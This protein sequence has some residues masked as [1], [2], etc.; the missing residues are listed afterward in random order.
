MK[1]G[2]ALGG[3]GAKGLAHIPLLQVFDDLGIRPHRI[4]GTSIGA[5]IGAL[6]ASGRSA[7]EI[8]D[9]IDELLFAEESHEGELRFA[10]LKGLQ[11][12]GQLIDFDTSAGGI[13]KGDD[14]V[15]ALQSQLGAH[16]F[17][18][19]EIP[20]S[21]VATD[22]WSREPFVFES[23]S[24]AQAV[25]ASAS[26]PGLFAPVIEDGR[27]LMD[28][29]AVNPVPYDL[30]LDDCDKVVAID[31]SGQ[32]E[33]PGESLIPSVSDSIFNTFQIMSKSIVAEKLK[34]RR[35]DLFLRPDIVNVRLLEFGEAQVVYQQTESSAEEL[36]SWLTSLISLPADAGQEDALTT[37]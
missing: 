13:I 17:E 7:Q 21:I 19:L 29:G 22:F 12:L 37:S 4:A 28:G 20:M 32:R 1:I 2:L 35:P 14:I 27:V 23:G 11:I 5:V 25:R 34:Q 16:T 24:I 31:V 15:A 10:L 33:A 30:L 6:Y 8:R 26:L 36:R 18:D 3:G 9:G